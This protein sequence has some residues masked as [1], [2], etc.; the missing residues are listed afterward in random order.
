M[1]TAI[2]SLLVGYITFAMAAALVSCTKDT[3]SKSDPVDLCPLL[4]GV[5]TNSADC[6]PPPKNAAIFTSNPV[7]NPDTLWARTPGQLNWNTQYAT[8]TEITLGALAEDKKSASIPA[9]ETSA[10]TTITLTG[11]DGALVS[12]VVPI[13]VYDT[14]FTFICK[15]GSKWLENGDTTFSTAFPGGYQVSTPDQNKYIYYK[16]IVNGKR[17]GTAIAPNGSTST[18]WWNSLNNGAQ[19]QNGG[20]IYDNIFLSDTK[21]VMQRVYVSSG[22]QF[23]RRIHYKVVP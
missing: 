10:S 16:T 21:W 18:G 17:S 15:N 11:E 7:L 23:T 12:K 22:V 20:G 4:P 13:A 1:K 2:R 5:Q 3:P 8:K 9:L 14:M 19:F 6:P